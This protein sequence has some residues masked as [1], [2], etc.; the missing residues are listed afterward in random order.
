M[1]NEIARLGFMASNTLPRW[2]L[3][4]MPKGSHSELV[5]SGRFLP[6]LH[7]G[8]PSPAL[9]LHCPTSS[10]AALRREECLSSTLH[11]SRCTEVI[12]Q[13]A[14]R[15]ARPP[16]FAAWHGSTHLPTWPS[17]SHSTM[18]AA[19]P[20]EGSVGFCQYLELFPLMLFCWMTTSS[21]WTWVNSSH[22]PLCWLDQRG[23]MEG[24]M[25]RVTNLLWEPRDSCW[26][27]QVRCY[28]SLFL[29]A[30]PFIFMLITNLI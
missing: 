26:G 5:Q 12:S 25:P 20:Q 10:H 4:A 16:V 29:L 19:Q 17:L 9:S 28:Q 14:Q 8:N 15:P 7:T 22:S 1:F 18:T 23:R 24:R 6:N 2:A 27:W 30:K 3:T 21:A 13:Q 11:D